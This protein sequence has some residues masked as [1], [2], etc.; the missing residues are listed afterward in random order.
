MA[1]E[2]TNI[3]AW[4]YINKHSNEF[5]NNPFLILRCCSQCFIPYLPPS[6]YIDFLKKHHLQICEP[7]TEKEPPNNIV[8]ARKSYSE[9]VSAVKKEL[10]I[11]MGRNRQDKLHCEHRYAFA[12][13]RQ[14]LCSQWRYTFLIGNACSSIIVLTWILCVWYCYRIA[15]FRFICWFG[16]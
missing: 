10:L 4:T 13:H 6:F 1:R 3:Q 16:L 5:Y 2:K 15:S 14:Y 8:R 11:A 7:P 12:K 9:K